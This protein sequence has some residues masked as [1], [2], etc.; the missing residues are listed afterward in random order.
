MT[1]VRP[2][3]RALCERAD[4]L[5]LGAG[6]G[7]WLLQ[8]ARR[9]GIEHPLGIDRNR[10]KVARAQASA[11]P[12]YEADFTSLDPDAFPAV[13]VVVFDNVL[14]HLP[15]LA[16][17]DAVLDRACAIASHVVYIRHPS[18]EHEEYLASLGLK[19]YWTDW[20]GVHTAH[21]RL[22]EFVAMA[23]R[24]GVYGCTVRPLKRAFGSDDPT[25]LPI[26]APPNQRKPVRGIG[27][28]GLYDE[29][30]HGAKPVVVFDRPVYFAFDV[31][32]LL[33]S[34]APSVQYRVDT[35]EAEARPL[36]LWPDRDDSPAPRQAA[37]QMFR[38]LTTALRKG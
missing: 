32:F 22:H 30:I 24:T 7:Q 15:S 14:E 34:D 26:S 36:L 2:L 4:L 3:D 1:N 27:A 35:D 9:L 5:N 18:F 31:F 19:Q 21:V 11:L 25:I 29:A 37:R 10:T 13:K 17:V 38:S 8:E 6:T 33:R 16:S 12:V 23:A 20:P 28:Y